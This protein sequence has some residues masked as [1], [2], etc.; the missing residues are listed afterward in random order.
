MF[1][2]INICNNNNLKLNSTNRNIGFITNVL[3]QKKYQASYLYLVEEKNKN[4]I[5]HYHIILGVKT[6]TDYNN[7][8]K[9]NILNELK[10]DISYDIVIKSIN[11]FEDLKKT[12]VY[13]WKD[14]YSLEKNNFY[15]H[16]F[17]IDEFLLNKNIELVSMLKESSSFILHPINSFKINLIDIGSC[18]NNRLSFYSKYTLILMIK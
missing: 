2:T 1:I 17:M 10:K 12:F 11:N 5:E 16:R 7:H 18:H 3:K 14:S 4:N 9:L 8:F 13:I 6:L 15:T